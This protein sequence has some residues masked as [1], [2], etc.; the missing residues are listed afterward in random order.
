MIHVGGVHFVRVAKLTSMTAIV[1][2]WSQI[3]RNKN[4]R[5]VYHINHIIFLF[6]IVLDDRRMEPRFQHAHAGQTAQVV[7]I[8]QLTSHHCIYLGGEN[9]VYEGFSDFL[10]VNQVFPQL[11]CV[12]G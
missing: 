4:S 2:I 8:R 9:V 7:H 1:K 12:F 10:L 3:A 6:A 5:I 11:F